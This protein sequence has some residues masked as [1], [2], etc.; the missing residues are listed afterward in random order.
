MGGAGGRGGRATILSEVLPQCSL[1]LLSRTAGPWR[2]L[3][4][5]RAPRRPRLGSSRLVAEQVA[6]R[7]AVGRLAMDEPALG[8]PVVVVGRSVTPSAVS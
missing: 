6:G 4:A 3:G 5:V 8:L 7:M 2:R 1:R